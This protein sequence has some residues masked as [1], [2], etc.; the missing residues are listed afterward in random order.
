LSG[1]AVECSCGQRRSFGDVF[2]FDENTGGPLANIGCHCRGLRPWLGDMDSSVT[3]CGH[4]LRVLQRGAT[5]VYFPHVVSSIYLPLWAEL[6]ER[7]IIESLERP[8]IWDALTNGLVDGKKIDPVRCDVVAK[9]WNLNAGDLLTVAQ[10]KLDG[11]QVEAVRD[12]EEYRRQEYS[13]LLAPRG[14]PE[15]DLYVELLPANQLGETLSRYFS[16]VALV[17]KL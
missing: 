3:P 16:C 15:T 9:M 6:A 8:E 5:N 4:F 14:G 1:I 2:R 11:F 10:R 7:S 13:A 12:E 17:K